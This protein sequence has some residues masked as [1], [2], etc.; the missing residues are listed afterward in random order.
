MQTGNLVFG[1]GMEKPKKIRGLP[2]KVICDREFNAV[3]HEGILYVLFP[4][5]QRHAGNGV[6]YN[7]KTNAFA[8]AISGFKHVGQ[9]WY[10]WG[11]PE[12]PIKLTQQYE[13]QKP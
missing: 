3:S 6:A 4:S 2:W 10:A 9:H 5:V 13:G 12:D 11:Q 1:Y 8:P 7:P